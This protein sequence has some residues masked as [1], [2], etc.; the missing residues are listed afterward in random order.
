MIDGAEINIGGKFMWVYRRP[1][2]RDWAFLAALGMWIIYIVVVFI[3][4]KLTVGRLVE[5]AV[6]LPSILLLIGILVGV[7]REYKRGLRG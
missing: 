6:A 2:L 1:L 5:C 3:Q 4:Y 7:P